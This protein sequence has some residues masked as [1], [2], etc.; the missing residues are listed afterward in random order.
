MKN[1]TQVPENSIVACVNTGTDETPAFS[2][3][4]S[5]NTELL[6]RFHLGLLLRAG[7]NPA[8]R[9]KKNGGLVTPIIVTEDQ[10]QSSEF[11]VYD[12]M[13]PYTSNL[14]VDEE[15]YDIV[16]TSLAEFVKNNWQQKN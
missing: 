2:L 4:A 11:H 7:L 8:L 5:A 16:K 13:V 14:P 6:H 1:Q 9:N 15:T 10:L 12:L 3:V